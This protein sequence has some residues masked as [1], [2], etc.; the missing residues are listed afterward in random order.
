M[1]FAVIPLSDATWSVDAQFPRFA[2]TMDSVLITVLCALPSHPTVAVSLEFQLHTNAAMDPV[3]QIKPY[4]S[5]PMAA[6]LQH[7]KNVLP[8][9]AVLHSSPLVHQPLLQAVLHA[10]MVVVFR[11]LLIAMH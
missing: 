8:M 11:A 6:A 9:V 7:R 2:V 3:L 5:Y 1:A 4:V 10:L